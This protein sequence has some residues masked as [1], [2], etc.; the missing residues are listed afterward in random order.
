M[1]SRTHTWEKHKRF[2][3]TKSKFNREA[4]RQN[5][6]SEW[7]QSKIKKE[8]NFTEQEYNKLKWN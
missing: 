1:K 8:V 3:K 5:H 6:L 7:L 2:K 4:S